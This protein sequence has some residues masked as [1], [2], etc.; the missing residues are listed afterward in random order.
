MSAGQ[1]MALAHALSDRRIDRWW[2]V[3][4][5]P[6]VDRIAAIVA[7]LGP[8]ETVRVG[9]RLRAAAAVENRGIGA[10]ADVVPPPAEALGEVWDA[11]V[12]VWRHGA[13]ATHITA[14]TVV[15]DLYLET[16]CNPHGWAVPQDVYGAQV[17]AR[18]HTAGESE[19]YGVF[20]RPDGGR[21][22]MVARDLDADGM[23]GWDGIPAGSDERPGVMPAMATWLDGVVRNHTNR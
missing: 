20:W 22:R 19:A 10:P 18:A 14:V 16:W 15:P 5:G 2:G 1:V 13:Q 8:A 6:D 9:N 21:W 17:I 11:P 4:A 7:T 23:V 3:D 12:R